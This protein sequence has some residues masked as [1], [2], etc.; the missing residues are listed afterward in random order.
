MVKINVTNRLKRFTAA[1]KTLLPLRQ[2][3]FIA[4]S[5]PIGIAQ[6]E[7]AGILI[8]LKNLTL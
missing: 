7:R 6:Q 8:L 2:R 3:T 5:K 1:G 4:A